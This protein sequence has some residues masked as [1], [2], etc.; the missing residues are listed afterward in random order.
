VVRVLSFFTG[1]SRLSLVSLSLSPYSPL[2]YNLLG[3][4]HFSKEDFQLAESFFGKARVL[5]SKEALDSP[6]CAV[7]PHKLDGLLSACRNVNKFA[8]VCRWLLSCLFSLFC[9]FCLS[10]FLFLFLFLS[11]FFTPHD[12][13]WNAS[14]TFACPV[15]TA[16]R[17]ARAAL[18][19]SPRTQAILHW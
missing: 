6:L 9:F 14:H 7:E 17:W 18:L 2:W 10:L 12:N 19:R 16:V 8:E 4:Y 15:V 11:S 1:R 3:V 5:L 13:S